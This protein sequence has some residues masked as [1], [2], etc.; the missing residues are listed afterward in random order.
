MNHAA[1]KAVSGDHAVWL[2]QRIR[3][4]FH[5]TWS[6]CRA[7]RSR[8]VAFRR[9]NFSEGLLEPKKCCLYRS[10]RFKV[11]RSGYPL[12]FDNW[13]YQNY[14]EASPM[15]PPGTPSPDIVLTEK[16]PRT[17]STAPRY[18]VAEGA[19][20]FPTCA[21]TINARDVPHAGF[22]IAGD[23]TFNMSTVHIL[24][25]DKP[26]MEPVIQP[27]QMAVSPLFFGFN[28]NLR[29]FY[30]ATSRTLVRQAC[31]IIC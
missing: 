7:C 12:A 8:P 13:E 16:K 17:V 10:L 11:R 31:N 1:S 24:D 6:R 3:G 26:L 28:G 29:T 9:S 5:H 27:R 21:A 19:V 25:K 18:H 15:C 2:S 23:K 22:K 4:R 20:P 30:A 14:R